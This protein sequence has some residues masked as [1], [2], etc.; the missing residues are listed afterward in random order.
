MADRDRK[1]AGAKQ[2][3]A[4]ALVAAL[5][6][7]PVGDFQPPEATILNFTGPSCGID[8]LIPAGPNITGQVTYCD[9]NPQ[10]GQFPMAALLR[11]GMPQTFRPAQGSTC[12]DARE[13][14]GVE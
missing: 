3:H 10:S 5:Q 13:I 11:P 8:S 9:E 12:I 1:V 2:H 6:A 14:S 7:T 4:A